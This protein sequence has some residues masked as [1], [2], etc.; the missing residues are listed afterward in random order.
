M[1]AGGTEK[2]D[3]SACSGCSLCL[4]VCPTW[5]ST[6]DLRMTPHGRAKALQ[7]GATLADITPSVAACTLCGACEPVCPENIGVVDA[8]LKFRRELPPA[9]V[10]LNVQDN[11]QALP[12]RPLYGPVPTS[13][14]LLASATHKWRHHILARVRNVL[15]GRRYISIEQDGGVDISLAL[16]I[17][18]RIPGERLERFLAPLKLRETIIVADGLLLRH[19]REWLPGRQIVALG[20]ALSMLPSVRRALKPGDLYVIEPRAYHLDHSVMVRYYDDL[21]AQTGCTMNLDLNRIAVPA[22]AP[23]LA[24]GLLLETPADAQQIRWILQGRRDVRRIVIESE[25]DRRAFERDCTIPVMHLAEIADDE[26]LQ[27]ERAG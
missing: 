3:H 18:A 21:R 15:G 19:L 17:G 2:R 16:E 9:D 5:L 10:R 20:W 1:H 22:R 8:V 12:P 11:M 23:G 6:R 4:L 25:L 24:Q 14:T 7:H 27:S 13:V 26:V